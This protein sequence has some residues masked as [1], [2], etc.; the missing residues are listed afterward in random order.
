M[1]I[2]KLKKVQRQYHPSY[3]V[4]TYEAKSSAKAEA[5]N[6][7]TS[8]DLYISDQIFVYITL[9]T[10]DVESISLFGKTVSICKLMARLEFRIAQNIHLIS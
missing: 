1:Y 5:I 4:Q 6:D 7:S 9:T 2:L 3:Y 10:P 8:G